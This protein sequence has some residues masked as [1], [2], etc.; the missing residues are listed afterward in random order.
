MDREQ[1]AGP[2]NENM[3]GK[4]RKRGEEREYRGKTASMSEHEHKL[5]RK[6]ICQCGVAHR[7]TEKRVEP[8]L[9][10]RR[11]QKEEFNIRELGDQ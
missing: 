3:E 6:V 2:E 5:R 8:Q 1:S 11:A 7:C 9:R 10:A 4:L